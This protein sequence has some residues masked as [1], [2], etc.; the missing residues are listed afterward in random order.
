MPKI[1][2]SFTE[3]NTVLRLLEGQIKT[4]A[5]TIQ[6]LSD[7]LRGVQAAKTGGGYYGG[8]EIL[9]AEIRS[10]MG[11]TLTNPHEVSDGNLIITDVTT[12][13]VSITAHGFCPKAPNDVGQYLSG[14]GTWVAL[15]SSDL[16]STG[17]FTMTSAAAAKTVTDTAVTAGCTILWAPTHSSAATI[18]LYE[19]ARSAGASFTVTNADG[20]CA[21]TETFQYAIFA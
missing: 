11:D 9:M 12:N 10:H 14:L 4:Q 1:V 21:G 17:T 7:R 8:S 3:L 15:P 2:T 16:L 6:N 20:A 18:H 13:D 19:S 5:K